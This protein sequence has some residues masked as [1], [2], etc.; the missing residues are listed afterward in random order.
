MYFIKDGIKHMRLKFYLE[1]TRRRG[2]A[3]VEVKKVSLLI[4]FAKIIIKDIYAIIFNSNYRMNLI[5]MNIH[6]YMLW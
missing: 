6:I 4:V 1:G 5:N 2:T 3:F